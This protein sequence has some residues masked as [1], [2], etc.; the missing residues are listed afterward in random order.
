[1]SH[2]LGGA[3][4]QIFARKAFESLHR[5]HVRVFSEQRVEEREGGGERGRRDGERE[6]ERERERARECE[7]ERERARESARERERARETCLICAQ[8]KNI[9]NIIKSWLRVC[10]HWFRLG[11]VGFKTQAWEHHYIH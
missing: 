10:V 4:R 2:E 11:L 5:S 8:H 1:V 9:H 3:W 6:S 7:R